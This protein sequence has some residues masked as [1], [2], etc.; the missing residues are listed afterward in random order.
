MGLNQADLESLDQ[1]AE[2]DRERR[3]EQ[4]SVVSFDFDEARCDHR[5][6]SHLPVIARLC[7][8]LAGT[9]APLQLELTRQPAPQRKTWAVVDDA[10]RGLMIHHDVQVQAKT[11]DHDE[12]LD[13]FW[14][15]VGLPDAFAM[16]SL[17]G[18]YL[19]D[20]SYDVNLTPIVE[21]NSNFSAEQH[22]IIV[23]EYEAAMLSL[24]Y[25]RLKPKPPRV[26]RGK[27]PV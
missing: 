21:I 13:I 12:F 3:Y 19:F 15:S 6:E 5:F 18:R 7:E 25:P 11:R 27:G 26:R 22:A 4:Q 16:C 24:G 9:A 10:G 14:S 1:Q 17:F 23:Q 20:G 2:A 8:R